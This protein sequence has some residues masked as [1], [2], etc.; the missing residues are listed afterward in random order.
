MC[1]SIFFK[2]CV[3]KIKCFATVEKK[4]KKEITY[5]KDCIRK[6]TF[7]INYMHYFSLQMLTKPTWEN[8]LFGYNVIC[9]DKRQ[10]A[11]GQTCCEMKSGKYGCCD[12]PNVRYHYYD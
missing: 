1:A 2:I 7:K 3:Q 10:C 8:V 4:C 11:D 12:M 6:L 9:T 5:L